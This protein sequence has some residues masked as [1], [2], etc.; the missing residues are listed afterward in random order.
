MALHDE[1][2]VCRGLA[3]TCEAAL[4][5]LVGGDPYLQA[6][7]AALGALL[8]LALVRVW[9]TARTGTEFPL[10]RFVI[11]PFVLWSRVESCPR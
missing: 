5:L 10:D 3:A 4:A 7:A 2:E 1:S 6:A 9:W 11:L 8:L